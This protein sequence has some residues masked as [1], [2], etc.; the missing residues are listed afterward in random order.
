M[1]EC[2]SGLNEWA[3]GPMMM[4]M[5]NACVCTHAGA[6]TVGTALCGFF[7]DRLFN[8]RGTGAADPAMNATLAARLAAECPN[9]FFTESDADPAVAL[10]QATPHA[11]DAAWFRQIAAG[12]AVL[13]IDAELAGP[14]ADVATAAL[15]AR[16]AAAGG[17]HAFFPAFARSLVRMANVGVLTRSPHGAAPLGEVR[18]LCNQSNRAPHHHHHADDDQAHHPHP[19]SR[20]RLHHRRPRP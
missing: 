11:F 1:D 17:E 4:T 16:F 14:A 15:V 13:Q 19:R 7:N 18:I 10:D 8:F 3:D 9:P 12:N 20:P 5:M 6:H 2:M